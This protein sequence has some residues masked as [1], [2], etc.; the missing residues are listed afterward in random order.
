[1][2]QV[3]AVQLDIRWEEREANHARV[4]ELL[5]ADRPRLGALVVLPEM[6]AT[7]FTMSVAA[8]ADDD[9]GGA[10]ES[11]L[12]ALSR[13]L[14]VWIVAGLVHRA[15]DGASRGRGANEAFAFSP[16]GAVAARYTK[17]HPFS[18][19]RE[20]ENYVA[21]DDVVTFQWER[22]RAA[23]LVCYDLR[24]P[25][26]FRLATRAGA[27]MFT[28]IANW[29]ESRVDHWV[30][31]LRARAIENQAYVVGVNRAGADPHLRY[32]GRSLVVDPAGK[33]LADAGAGE[34]CI[35]AEV[36]YGVLAE[37]RARFP[38]VKDMRGDL[39]P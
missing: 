3:V 34:S 8:A 25:E 15:P 12:S 17:L 28:V 10:S 35:S 18:L 39:L 20:H 26:A 31:L 9:A 21:G 27:E 29:P 7:G 38:F 1:M 37:Y 19:G 11:F 23:P 6:F 33:V 13:E 30:T 14:G 36:D 5:V 2:Q 32:P 16:D 4:R 24:F 22:L